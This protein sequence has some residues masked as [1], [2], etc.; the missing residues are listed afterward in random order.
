[1]VIYGNNESE[2]E[3]VD[4]R[5]IDKLYA[6][7]CGYTELEETDYGGIVGRR[8]DGSINFIPSPTSNDK[9]FW[10]LVES[11][12]KR[13]GSL[14]ITFNQEEKEFVINGKHRSVD[15]KFAILKAFMEGETNV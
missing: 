4:C 13:C 10:L 15:L 11:Y 12:V 6:E 1:M 3:A 7:E 2:G 8:P 14:N 5:L 9:H